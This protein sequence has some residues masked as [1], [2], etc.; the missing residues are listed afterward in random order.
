MARVL[1]QQLER[2]ESVE[3][4]CAGVVSSE[5]YNKERYN[6]Y[7]FTAVHLPKNITAELRTLYDMVEFI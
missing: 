3:T 4:S 5:C 2:T 6:L 7:R 1:L